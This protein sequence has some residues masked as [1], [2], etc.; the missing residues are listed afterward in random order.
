MPTDSHSTTAAG[1]LEPRSKSPGLTAPTLLL[2]AICALV[3]FL[4]GLIHSI[5]GPLAPEIARSLQ[6][7]NS[8]L[9]PIFSAN[10]IGQCLGLVVF[11]IFAARAGQRGVVL[12]SLVGFGVAQNCTALS[13]GGTSLF[14]WRL[15][16]G[17]FLGGCLPS[18]NFHAPQFP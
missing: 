3:Y 13:D 14:V 15:I 17:V 8:E 7:S 11:P 16:T 6:L 18:L 9:G 1:S 5:L 4:D 12:V 10:L 2:I